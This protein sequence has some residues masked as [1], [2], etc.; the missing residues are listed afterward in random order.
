M[1]INI[2]TPRLLLREMRLEDAA[3]MFELDSNPNVLKYIYHP[4]QTHISESVK[5]IEYVLEQ[6]EAF[7]IG[8]WAMILKETGEFV[9]WTGL[10]M[11]TKSMNGHVNYLDLG[12]RLCERFWGQGYATESAIASRDY[13]FDVLKAEKICGITALENL[14]SQR[15]LKK[16]GMTQLENFY[17]DE[18]DVPLTWFE[19]WSKTGI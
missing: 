19:M 1:K 13:A 7:G 8:R 10:K 16:V 18:Y 6:Y 4:P 11:M 15:I 14:G 17:A 2:E 9:G 3:G 12:Y 5:V